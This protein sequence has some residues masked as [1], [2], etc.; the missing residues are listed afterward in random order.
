[1][2]YT[3][4]ALSVVHQALL[5][6]LTGDPVA[7]PYFELYAGATLLATLTIDGAASSVSG[8]TGVLTLVPGDPLAAVA[9]GTITSAKLLAS[10]DAIMD[11]A[12]P[13]AV[14]VE[15]VSG[16]LVLSSLTLISGGT[17]TLISA[18]IG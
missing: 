4:A 7:D 14:G 12:V 2:A 8:V 3:P 11:S 13:I 6:R 9:S 18:S 17:I 16:T 5:D 10:D 1:M 15:A